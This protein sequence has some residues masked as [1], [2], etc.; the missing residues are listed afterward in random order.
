MSYTLAA[1]DAAADRVHAAAIVDPHVGRVHAESLACGAMGTPILTFWADGSP[2]VGALRFDP[3]RSAW[4][5]DV[6][7]VDETTADAIEAAVRA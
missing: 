2:G 7:G 6:Y 5:F 3:V 1:F 4:T